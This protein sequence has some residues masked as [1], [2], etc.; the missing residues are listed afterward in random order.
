MSS[1]WRWNNLGW[2]GSYENWEES[3][4]QEILV[5]PLGRILL[6]RQMNRNVAWIEDDKRQIFTLE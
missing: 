1:P 3:G 2:K 4:W 6:L 5:R